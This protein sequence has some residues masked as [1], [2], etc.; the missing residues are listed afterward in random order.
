MSRLAKATVTVAILVAVWPALA[1]AQ[2]TTGPSREDFAAAADQICEQPYRKAFRRL[3]RAGRLKDRGF[4]VKAG[5]T[6][7]GAGS[8]TL[9]ALKRVGRLD[10]PVEDADR[11]ARWLDEMRPGVRFLNKS[12]RALADHHPERSKRLL[13]K[14]NRKVRRAKRIVSDLGMEIC[15]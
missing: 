14:S 13:K 2:T 15:A 4:E 5:K 6:L 12:G 11:I 10:R 8:V 1:P 7:V 3:N 9:L